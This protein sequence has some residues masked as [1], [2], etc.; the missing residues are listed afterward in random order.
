M[1]ELNEKI[2]KEGK[3]LPHNVVKVNSFLNHQID[4]E[5]LGKIGQEFYNRFKDEKIT[6][7][8]TIEAS[9]IP[10]A[11]EVARLFKSRVLFA[12][13]GKTTNMSDEFYQSEIKS[14][15][16]NEIYNIYV[17]KEFLTKDDTVLLIDDF[18][19]NGEAFKGLLD[20]V[21]KSGAKC[22][23]CGVVIEKG[24]QPGGKN[25]RDSGTRLES[26]AIIDEID[27]KT[28]TIKFRGE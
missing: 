16:H 12:K 25:L 24:F 4:V 18:L 26:L 15:T 14:Y 1:K 27:E 10:I 6:K 3:I 23:G 22:V 28:Q 7:V 17:A 21:G 20:I 13:K 8:L 5:F 11:C 2:L 9:G 19:A